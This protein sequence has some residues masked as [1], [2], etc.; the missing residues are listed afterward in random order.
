MTHEETK[1]FETGSLYVAAFLTATVNIEPEY[2]ARHRFTYFLYPATDIVYQA[3]A[4][5]NGGGPV[6]AFLYAETIKR[7]RGEML[8][9]RTGADDGHFNR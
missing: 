9:R 7:L 8:N 1:H 5:F 2:T 4:A 3:L 6:N